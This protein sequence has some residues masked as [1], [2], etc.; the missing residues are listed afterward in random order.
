MDR[1]R[2]GPEG[3][4]REPVRAVVLS[5]YAGFFGAYYSQMRRGGVEVVMSYD[6]PREVLNAL[7][8]EAFPQVDVF[9]TELFLPTLED[10]VSETRNAI[11]VI[12]G[13]R[14]HGLDLPVVA[15]ATYAF[16]QEGD[17][18]LLQE[19]GIIADQEMFSVASASGKDM[20]ERLVELLKGR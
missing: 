14:A 15:V 2:Q 3:L 1:D 8:S 11:A 9:L 10:G 5:D 6:S 12:K 13:L 7:G 16:F 19:A 18:V 17:G 20:S 4:Q